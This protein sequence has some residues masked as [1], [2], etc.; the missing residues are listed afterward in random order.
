MK[1]RALSAILLLVVAFST[2]ASAQDWPAKPIRLV[3]SLAPG[4]AAD[5]GARLI[6][7]PLSAAL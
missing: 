4:G 6:A 7:E 3:V 5:V 2:P 1:R